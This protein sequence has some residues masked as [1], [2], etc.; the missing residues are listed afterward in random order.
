[1]AGRNIDF[2]CDYLGAKI[3]SIAIVEAVARCTGNDGPISLGYLPRPRNQ[4]IALALDE[5]LALQAR[6]TGLSDRHE[7]ALRLWVR[8]KCR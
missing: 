6:L 2:A 1:M 7:W 8:I 4:R 3:T 5:G